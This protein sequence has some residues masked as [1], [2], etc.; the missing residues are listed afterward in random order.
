[1]YLPD[2]LKKG[3]LIGI[4]ACSNGILEKE[5]RYN[6]SVAHFKEKGFQIIETDDVRKAGCAPKEI[7]ARELMELYTNNQVKL[8]AVASGGDFLSDMLPLIDFETMK[9]NPKWLVG[10]SDPTSLLFTMTTKYDIATIYTPCNMS[11]FN[12]EK[13]HP[14]LETYFDVI[15]GKCSKQEKYDLCEYPSFSDEFSKED[16]WENLN[17]DV[18]EEGMLIGGC[19]ECLKDIIGTP[20]DHVSAFVEKYKGLIWYFDIFNMTSEG[21]YNTLNQFKFAGWFNYCKAIL[22]GRVA[23]PNTF[24]DK[25]YQELIKQALP[26]TKIIFN[27][28]LG[29]VAPAFT[30]INGAQ[31]HIVSNEKEHYLEYK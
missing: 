2:F 22:F 8:I 27:F 21:V 16:I 28:D 14:C 9:N 6:K 18:N 1:M 4:T 5:E 26:D 3:D 10:S 24:V 12:K 25:T 13:L 30:L 11:G 31:V 23:F 19:I 15:M 29:H 17:G 7:R 20:V